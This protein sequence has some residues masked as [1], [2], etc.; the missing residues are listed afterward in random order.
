VAPP[1]AQLAW[2]AT[3]LEELPPFLQSADVFRPLHHPPQDQPRDLSLGGLLLAADALAATADGFAPAS[4]AVWEKARRQ[5]QEESDRHAASIERKA[6]AELSHRLN[7][8]RAYLQDLEEKPREA[9]SY[10]IEVRHRVIIDRLL[11][12]LAGREVDKLSRLV[13]IDDL[14]RPLFRPGPFVW[15]AELKQV[16]PEKSFWYL[17]GGPSPR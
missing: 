3:A 17:Y 1:E 14:L 9:E 11:K 12:I 2:F 13:Q 15:P 16:Y 6:S 4:R 8:W 7:L 10:A 5:W